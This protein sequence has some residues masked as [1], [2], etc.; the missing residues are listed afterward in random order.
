LKHNLERL[1]KGY[2]TIKKR[3]EKGVRLQ[4]ALIAVDIVNCSVIALQGGSGYR[5]TQFNR[6]LLGKRQPGSL[7]KPFVFLTAFQ[8]ASFEQPFNRDTKLDG[9]SFEWTYDKQVWKPRNYDE[10]SPTEVTAAEALQQSINIP[11]ARLAQMVGIAEIQANIKKSGVQSEIPVF[12]SISLGSAEVSPFELAESFTTLANLG[13]GCRL[14]PV[15]QIFDENGNLV[16]DFPLGKEPRL[17]PE[18]TFQ[19]VDLLRG[20]F[21]QGTAKTAQDSGLNL[22]N[23]AGKTGTT[24]DFKDAWFVGFSPEMLALVWVGY[25]EADKVGLTG[26]AAALPLWVEFMK[27]S[28]P[29]RQDRPFTRP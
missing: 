1:T 3:E 25:D 21:T 9:T 19:T 13:M 14:R 20:V 12:P 16:M 18:A 26:A 17:N 11:T 27:E 7:F 4:S 29:F 5:Q 10:D 22:E 23:F 6:I 28:K 2:A 24:N 8:K 15:T